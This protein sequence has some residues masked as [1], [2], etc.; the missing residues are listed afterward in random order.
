MLNSDDYRLSSRE[1]FNEWL[2]ERWTTYKSNGPLGVMPI[3][4]EYVQGVWNG[5]SIGFY[6]AVYDSNEFEDYLDYAFYE[7]YTCSIFQNLV[8]DQTIDIDNFFPDSLRQVQRGAYDSWKELRCID[9]GPALHNEISNWPLP[10]CLQWLKEFK[11]IEGTQWGDGFSI[12][13]GDVFVT[14]LII[15]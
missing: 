9:S 10:N 8:R 4:K 5:K 15:D 13:A 11:I 7:L 2:S 14:L 12:N 6:G 3:K 1:N